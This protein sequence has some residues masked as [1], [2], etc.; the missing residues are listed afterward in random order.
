MFYNNLLYAME[1]RSYL[2]DKLYRIYSIAA[3]LDTFGYY[4]FTYQNGNFSHYIYFAKDTAS[5]LSLI[6]I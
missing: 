5:N 3:N 2:D 4:D 6:H 1:F